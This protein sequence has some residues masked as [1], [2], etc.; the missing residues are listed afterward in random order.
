[1]REARNFD[2]KTYLKGYGWVVFVAVL[3][4]APQSLTGWNPASAHRKQ[5][6]NAF[7]QL[8]ITTRIGDS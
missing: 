4:V 5:T 3:F 6:S 1:M 8:N 2:E 7:S